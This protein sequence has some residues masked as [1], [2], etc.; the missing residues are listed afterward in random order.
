MRSCLAA[1]RIWV[2]LLLCLVVSGPAS[3]AGSGHG[4]VAA[5]ADESGLA[6][7]LVA[8][9]RQ[10]SASNGSF[11]QV[12]AGGE[13]SCALRTDGTITCW[14]RNVEG[15][16]D[17]PSGS[18]SQISAGWHHSCG[19]RDDGTITCW[20]NNTYGQSDAPVGFVHPDIRR[21]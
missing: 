10:G 9:S 21:R 12:S 15:R 19:L 17:A 8:Q 16:L 18:F 3:A 5:L 4:P 1:S 11:S 20:G 7:S 6:Y 13:H 2:V 14:G